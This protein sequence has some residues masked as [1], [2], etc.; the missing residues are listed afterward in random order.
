M[1]GDLGTENVVIEKIQRVMR[2]Q[3]HDDTLKDAAFLY[4]KSCMNQVCS[5]I[6]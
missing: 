6:M 1:R 3:L 4:G 2:S 5:R